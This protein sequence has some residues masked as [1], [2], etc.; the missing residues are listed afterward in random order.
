DLA[1]RTKTLA[2]RAHEIQTTGLIGPYEKTFKD[3]EEKLAQARAV[4]SARNATTAAVSTLMELIE[5][6]SSFAITILFCAPGAYDS[7]R[8][9]YNMSRDAERRANESTTTKPSAVSQ[10]ADTRR[11]TERLISAKKDDF[12]RKN[13]ANKRALGD[14]KAKAQGLD[15]KK[16]NEKVKFIA[17]FFETLLPPLNFSFLTSQDVFNPVAQIKK[18]K[19][20]NIK[21]FNFLVFFH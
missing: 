18:R 13:G 11:R 19:S 2:E 16:L 6:L 12:N 17:S 14:L 4:V 10:S 21:W 5:D 7:I 8:S 9:S 3:L 15:M 1:V 20:L